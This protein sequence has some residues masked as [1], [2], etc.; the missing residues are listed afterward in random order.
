MA[1]KGPKK[2]SLTTL[3]AHEGKRLDHVLAEWLP[4]A[5][6]QPIS[7]GKVRKLI[8]AGAV[9]L[10]GSRVRIASKELRAR[11]RV[12][13][14]V[15]LAKLE[16]DAT[17]ADRSFEMSGEDILF[18]DEFLIAVNKPPGLPTQPT[19]DEARDNLYALVKKF[20]KSRDRVS[21]PYLGLHHRLD[22]DTSGV[23][24]FTKKTEANAG[25]A[26]LFS[27]RKAQ[28][29]YQALSTRSVSGS[30]SVI[31][32]AFEIK[33]YL[34]PDRG[35]PGTQKSTKKV[36]FTAVRSGGDFAH[37]SFRVLEK[38]PQAF[39]IEASP[40][41]G[42]THQIRVHLSESSLPILGDATYGGNLKLAPRLMLH[43]VSLT[44]P[45]P[46]HQTQISICSPL[47]KDF[48]QC[49]KTLKGHELP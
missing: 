4:E 34:G 49:L 19:L 32:D 48:T 33:N 1:G 17:Q 21:E 10:N 35:P 47:P 38:L 6:N 5:L 37:T 39:L 14:Y 12:D 9:Y 25:V 43:A 30:D 15:D 46:I 23:I 27:G 8:V 16:N 24:L 28:K 40:H 7:K 26:E 20:L 31:E 11:A 13:V 45:H 18:E 42:R 22:R 36:R 29:I 3:P 44:F 2:L 41:T